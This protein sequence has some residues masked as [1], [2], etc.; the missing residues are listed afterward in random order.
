[1]D[2]LKPCLEK[3]FREEEMRDPLFQVVE[4]RE[5][6]PKEGSG[7]RYK[8]A[9]SDGK[10]YCPAMLNS[11]SS[12]LVTNGE[13]EKYQIIRANQYTC[14]QQKKL[15]ILIQI[16]ILP[17]KYEVVL[18]DPT[19]LNL[20]ANQ[21]QNE[22]PEPKTENVH[23][24]PPPMQKKAVAPPPMPKPK[25]LKQPN[26]GS[27][28]SIGSLTSYIPSWEILARVVQK[29]AK[30]NW[31]TSKGN[32]VLFNIVLKDKSGE[33]IRGTF[34]NDEA[35]KFYDI[36]DVDKVYAISG[37]RIKNASKKFN[38]IKHDYEITFD[39]T[40]TFEECD[41]DQDSIGEISYNFTP[42]RELENCEVNK[43]VDVIGVVTSVQPTEEIHSNKKNKLLLKRTIVLSDSSNASVECTLWED[44]AKNFPSE[45]SVD[46]VLRIKNARVGEFHGKNLSVSADSI[47]K[48]LDRS[49]SDAAVLYDW[50]DENKD[51]VSTF[52]KISSGYG[53]G[54]Y[55]SQMIYLDQINTNNLGRGDT[56]DSFCAY[57]SLKDISQGRNLY[58]LAC[59]NPDCKNKGVSSEGDK[60]ICNACKQIV[61]SPVPRYAF[62][63]VFGDFSGTA[64]F[65]ILGDDGKNILEL[66]AEEWKDKTDGLEEVE[67]QKLVKPF[68][69]KDFKLK[70]RAKKETYNGEERVKMTVNS[71]TEID[72]A[73][74][75][76]FYA[77]EI[78][79]F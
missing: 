33:E 7:P 2:K 18:G 73:D 78:D 32:G 47:M 65:S 43:I 48:F 50:Y 39:K 49:D 70:A 16:E 74:A 38:N 23:P 26:S 1:M 72:Y 4:I 75:A 71:I 27:Y 21:T 20:K 45:I 42:L 19:Q 62:S 69:F 40:T 6:P 66:T 28:L 36:I 15:L 58:Y 77:G 22:A 12:Y 44:D 41:G 67:K 5:L 52:E 29:G 55:A 57:V 8:F 11:Q 76:K 3:I 14:V 37:G 31:S 10:H 63:A 34:F 46:R 53:G 68:L 54:D 30:K 51:N 79:K 59:P 9:I 24:N 64:F 13:L 25:P 56:P 61:E 35:E 17:E 60:F